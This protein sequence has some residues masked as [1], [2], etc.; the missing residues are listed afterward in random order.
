[1][2]TT[3][4]A[5]L[6]QTDALPERA[7][8]R[9]FA[10][11]LGGW[12]VP[13]PRL[14]VA[15]LAG[16][17][18]FSVALYSSGAPPEDAAEHVIDLF[19]DELSPPVAVLDAAAAALGHGAATDDDDDDD[20]PGASLR[21]YAL[22]YS[23]DFLHDDGWR[24]DLAGFERRF[25]RD[26]DEGIEAGVESP[27]DSQIDTLALDIP[28][29]A[30]DAQE[31]ALVDKAVRPHRGS[32]FLSGALG[33]PVL[34]AVMRATFE[35]ERRVAI[36]FVQPTAEGLR[37]ETERLVATLGRT[38]GRGAFAPPPAAGAPAPA[39]VAAFAAAYDWRDPRDPEDLYREL[40][41]G[42]VTGTLRFLREPEIA[43]FAPEPTWRSPAGQ[44]LYPVARLVPSAL[45]GHHEGATL[46]VA[47]DAEALYL[48]TAGH[49]PRL[50]GPTFGELVLYLALGW[51]KRT[52]AD[53]DL[54]GALMLRARLRAEK[55]P[56]PARR[57]PN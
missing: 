38:A 51:S 8:S 37:A 54:I 4:A 14:D 56:P 25:V 19:E 41:I 30:T 11:A 23:E 16:V 50:A 2:T 52:D 45:G 3:I 46:A 48:L 49:P 55:A 12:D 17:P 31:A 21:L 43:A 35:A 18:G 33:V 34:A 29:G 10:V 28:D 47:P 42:E 6:F 20:A 7:L 15:P 22:V 5:L 1:M 9:G 53:E 36:R 40:A 39:A 57:R 44:P 26:G 24:F 32:T 27:E 13:S